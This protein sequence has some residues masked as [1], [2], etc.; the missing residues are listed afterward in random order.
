VGVGPGSI[1][2]LAST[3]ELTRLHLYLDDDEVA[4]FVGR[5][6]AVIDEFV[7]SN[8]NREQRGA[9]SYGVLFASYRLA[10]RRQPQ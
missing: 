8:A 7:E 9:P 2:Q 10:D 4:D 1:E 5:V 6:R 3:V